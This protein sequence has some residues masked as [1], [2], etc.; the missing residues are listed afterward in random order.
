MQNKK[1]IKKVFNYT[2]LTVAAVFVISLIFVPMHIFTLYGQALITIFV[3]TFIA[4]IVTDIF[5]FAKDSDKRRHDEKKKD[6]R[7][8]FGI[9]R[10]L[11]FSILEWAGLIILFFIILGFKE[12]NIGSAA[13]PDSIQGN[14]DANFKIKYYYSP[15]CPSCW[16]QEPI[17]R[18]ML[19]TYGKDF[20]LEKYDVR[21]CKEEVNKYRISG[22]PSFVF[23]IIDESKEFPL[24]GFIAR[25]KLEDIMN[26]V[27]G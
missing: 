1:T 19:T 27:I 9:K 24:H 22:T 21:Y 11:F 23:T 6:T 15:F 20:S 26:D 14:V 18:D 8:I 4:S 5:Y 3:M 17:L 16:K 2:L 10:N 13:C 7:K 12:G 25:D